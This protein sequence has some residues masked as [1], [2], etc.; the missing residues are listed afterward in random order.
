METFRNLRLSA[1]NVRYAD[2]VVSAKTK[3]L[4]ISTKDASCCSEMC[5]ISLF[6]CSYK[7][8]DDL[9]TVPY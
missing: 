2:S 7:Q 6:L 5:R 3:T 4:S 9:Q 8:N 1:C